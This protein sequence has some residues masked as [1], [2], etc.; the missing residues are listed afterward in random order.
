[1]AYQN[2]VGAYG[3]AVG[4]STIPS[5]FF[6]N[7]DPTSYNTNFPLG[8]IWINQTLVRNWELISFSTSTGALLANWQLVSDGLAGD[9]ATI[10]A[11]DGTVVYPSSSNVTFVNGAGMDSVGGTNTITF[12]ATGGGYTWNLLDTGTTAQAIAVNNIYVPTAA[13]SVTLTLPTTAAFGEIFG[14]SGYGSGGWIIAQ[15][16]LQSIIFNSNSITTTGTGGSLASTLPSDF[17]MIVCL[18]ANTTFKMISSTGNI[19]IV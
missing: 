11:G 19:T 10:T 2:L 18:V 12:N 6:T 17:I 16:V 4:I 5:T 13:T 7:I 15:N 3:P 9:I 8:Q 14:V 1:M